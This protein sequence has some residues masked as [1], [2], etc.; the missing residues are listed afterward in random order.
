M[1]VH[2][3]GT[4]CTYCITAMAIVAFSVAMY[5]ANHKLNKLT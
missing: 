2:E 4:L 3:I 5:W 1:H